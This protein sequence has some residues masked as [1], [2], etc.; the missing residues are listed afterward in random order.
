MK[1]KTMYNKNDTRPIGVNLRRLGK[2]Y[3]KKWS[4]GR[5]PMAL[6]SLLLVNNIEFFSENEPLTGTD[7]EKNNAHYN[8]WIT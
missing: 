4:V 7:I 6:H 3:M 8:I 5:E 2:R 1:N